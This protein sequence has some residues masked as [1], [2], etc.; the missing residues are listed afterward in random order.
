MQST[1]TTNDIRREMRSNI[2]IDKCINDNNNTVNAQ[3]LCE[4]MFKGAVCSTL[5]KK[6]NNACKKA[7]AISHMV[8]DNV[9]PLTS[10]LAF[11]VFSE[12]IEKDTYVLKEWIYGSK[13]FEAIH[14][15]TCSYIDVYEGCM[16]VL[17]SWGNCK[18]IF[19]PSSGNIEDSTRR[20]VKSQRWK[21][22]KYMHRLQS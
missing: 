15:A 10:I 17:Q 4:S 2:N 18:D 11:I 21:L 13:L 16:N 20:I 12:G 6:Y 8:V 14:S 22:N 9:L 5:I 7:D 19:F 1:A 3:I